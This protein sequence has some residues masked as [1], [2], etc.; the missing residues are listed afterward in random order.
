[1]TLLLVMCLFY[2]MKVKALGAIYGLSC[3]HKG[4]SKCVL[5]FFCTLLPLLLLYAYSG[6]MLV[7]TGSERIREGVA[8][9]MKRIRSSLG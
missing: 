7:S 6:L 2:F 9:E 8:A 1:M 4:L 5:A 3:S